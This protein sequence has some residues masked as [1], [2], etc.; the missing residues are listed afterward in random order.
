[1]E[2][3]TGYLSQIETNGW[4]NFLLLIYLT[5]SALEY[6][7]KL[8]HLKYF[9]SNFKDEYFKSSKILQVKF[10]LTIL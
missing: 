2:E 8:K 7:D 1:M 9:F 4:N 10:T 3:Q 5:D 6:L